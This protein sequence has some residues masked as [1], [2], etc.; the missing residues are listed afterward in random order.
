MLKSV[1][2]PPGLFFTFWI[3]LFMSLIVLSAIKI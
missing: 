3:Y 1:Q 2:S